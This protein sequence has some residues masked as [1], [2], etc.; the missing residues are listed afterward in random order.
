MSIEEGEIVEIEDL[1]DDKEECGMDVVSKFSLNEI[2]CIDLIEKIKAQD[3]IHAHLKIKS[4]KLI[5]DVE[6][7][8]DEAEILECV[9]RR[10]NLEKLE[11]EFKERKKKINED[12]KIALEN[13][14]KRFKNRNKIIHELE[15]KVADSATT[16]NR[17]LN[18]MSSSAEVIVPNKK[19]VE[20]FEVLKGDMI[21]M[22]ICE[23]SSA[24]KSHCGVFHEM[25]RDYL[26]I[27]DLNSKFIQ[28]PWFKIESLKVL[29]NDCSHMK[30][31]ECMKAVVCAMVTNNNNY[32]LELLKL[33]TNRVAPIVNFFKNE[34]MNYGGL[35]SFMKNVSK[36]SSMLLVG[37]GSGPEFE[38][39]EKC[40]VVH[41]QSLVLQY[42]MWSDGVVK[43][44]PEDIV[45]SYKEAVPLKA[46]DERMSK[47][48]KS[49]SRQGHIPQ[50]WVN[51]ALM[52]FFED[53]SSGASVRKILLELFKIA[54]TY[55]CVSSA[56]I[57]VNVWTMGGIKYVV[58]DNL[59]TNVMDR[60]DKDISNNLPM[61]QGLM[62]Q[63]LEKCRT[64][65]FESLAWSEQIDKTI[66][67]VMAPITMSAKRMGFTID[68]ST[69]AK[70]WKVG[71]KSYGGRLVVNGDLSDLYSNM[72]MMTRVMSFVLYS[73]RC[74][75]K[76]NYL[77]PE[78]SAKKKE[79]ELL[80][81]VF[82]VL[83]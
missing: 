30:A 58:K 33:E 69:R 70:L 18:E 20:E 35:V 78:L 76:Y 60:L 62:I 45:H 14:K 75:V 74:Q 2:V 7:E 4:E 16:K 13:V 40:L 23:F 34:A 11:K 51:R 64:E 47:L 38:H 21:F 80:S 59:D 12:S 41:W 48:W 82:N 22:D 39:C 44:I 57:S 49:G 72:V 15:E 71:R 8:T 81:G 68:A 5:A 79:L 73:P 66:L 9:E 29:K 6:E 27:H 17:I 52:H 19:C 3:N 83:I 56:L 24:V 61:Q 28:V 53:G 1:C 65:P 26:A 67:R 31:L 54:L 46:S 63:T 43:K 36:H 42:M 10:K 55:A 32:H 50:R 25:T 37:L 77:F